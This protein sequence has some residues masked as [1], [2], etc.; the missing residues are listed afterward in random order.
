MAK[1]QTRRSISVMGVTYARLHNYTQRVGKSVSGLLEEL[2]AAKLDA[3]GEPMVTREQVR[4]PVKRDPE[5]DDLASGI[6]T[7]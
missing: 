2:I 4:A 5:M 6:F 7:F 3:E 1:R